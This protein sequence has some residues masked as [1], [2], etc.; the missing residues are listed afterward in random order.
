MLLTNRLLVLAALSGWS[1]PALA[2]D[3]TVVRAARMLDVARG[4][5][6]NPAVV[7]IQGCA[8]DAEISQLVVECKAELEKIREQ[9]QN[10]E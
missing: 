8:N 1:V 2:Q 7:T 6:V 5:I 9:V 10:V 4:Q 3:V